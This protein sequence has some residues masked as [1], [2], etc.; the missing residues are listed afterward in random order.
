M[1]NPR[2][3]KAA[4]NERKEEFEW[5][6]T[7]YESVPCICFILN[8]ASN[9]LSINQFG[10]QRLSY[11]A[12]ELIGKPIFN[13]FHPE[14]HKS[15][16]EI[17]T[18]SLENPPQLVDGEFRQL[19]ADGSLLWVRLSFQNLQQLGTEPV[20]LLFCEEITETKQLKAELSV[21]DKQLRLITES[22]PGKV[23]Y[24]DSQRR[25][26][27]VSQQYG[28]W[29][30]VSPE[31]LLGQTVD[32]F[33]G[34]AAYAKIRDYVEAALAGRKVTYEINWNFDDGSER[35]LVVNYIPD[36]NE[37]GEV[38]GFIAVMQDLTEHKTSE[39]ALQQF[40]A[41]LERLV[42]QRTVELEQA[43]GKEKELG[44]LKSRI[45]ATISHEYRTPLTTIQSSAELLER[46][47]Q[48][49]S[50]EKRL[51]HL[52]RIQGSTKHLT[53]LVN[54]VLF[55]G[56]AEAGSLEFNPIPLN[57]EQF[58]LELVEQMRSNAQ[59]QEA[60]TF[61]SQGNCTNPSLDEKLLRQILTNLLSNAIK[62][63][64]DGGTVRFDLECSE[65][66]VTL[67]IQ[68]SGIGIP[69]TDLPRLF[70]SFHRASN[71]KTIPGTGL[72]LAIVKKCVDLHGGKITVDS[73]VGKGTTF[74]VM[75]PLNPQ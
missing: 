62:Y 66:V 29:S 38:L 4:L 69:N 58:S 64:P 35:Y 30:K 71:V 31:E 14:E 73:V 2:K 21:R 25:Y 47:H 52:H 23:S 34:A 68:D 54:D 24:V 63:S 8:A 48:K 43:L 40:N 74:T 12:Q 41:D 9:I 17:L 57:L 11:L 15:L 61:S 56:K 3:I 53:D 45:I 19:C 67:R 65:E 10:T 46:Y 6:K 28:E 72:G 18:C 36:I 49:L 75:L 1:T 13:I 26:R 39:E 51:T 55:V 33:M 59:N 5:Y 22:L 32:G 37:S 42:Q 44:E 27:F 60:I 50:E 7:V 20:F 16:S 70:E